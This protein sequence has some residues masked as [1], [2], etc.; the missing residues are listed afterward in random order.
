MNDELGQS[1]K[2]SW[3]K[4]HP[5]TQ[6]QAPQMSTQPC[7]GNRLRGL[8]GFQI[9]AATQLRPRPPNL[10]LWQK[11]SDFELIWPKDSCGGQAG[12]PSPDQGSVTAWH[13]GLE[14]FPRAHVCT[15]KEALC[16]QQKH[17]QGQL[18]GFHSPRPSSPGDGALVATP[19][20][21]VRQ[22][23]RQ[24]CPGRAEFTPVLS[25]GAHT[26]THICPTPFGF[27]RGFA[28]AARLIGSHS[29]ICTALPPTW[30][31]HSL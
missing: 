10:G 5:G 4:G 13:P 3:R 28:N 6:P 9:P 27:P 11:A 21:E 29:L 7:A 1:A 20:G 31:H 19:T 23:A 14:L 12:H 25:L 22:T 17:S 30:A 15:R 8:R 26:L 2:A 16:P 24:G 18:S